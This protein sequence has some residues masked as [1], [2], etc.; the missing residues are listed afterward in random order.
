[1]GKPISSVVVISLGEHTSTGAVI[2]HGGRMRLQGGSQLTTGTE[3][4]W[5]QMAGAIYTSVVLVVW[6]STRGGFATIARPKNAV[7]RVAGRRGSERSI[8]GAIWMVWTKYYC[9][10]ER[11][12]DLPCGSE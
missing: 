10:K 11:T 5:L 1:M 9:R 4:L 12:R 2:V 6:E 8:D 3:L 7:V